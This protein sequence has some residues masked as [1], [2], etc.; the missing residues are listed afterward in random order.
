MRTRDSPGLRRHVAWSLPRELVL[1][2]RPCACAETATRLRRQRACT[3][4][5][6][7][8]FCLLALDA[9]KKA[10]R[11]PASGAAH[12]AK[13]LA[14]HF[15]PHRSPP[16]TLGGASRDVRLHM[17]HRRRRLYAALECWR[18]QGPGIKSSTQLCAL[19]H[20]LSP[21]TVGCARR[22]PLPSTC[23]LQTMLP[24]PGAQGR[25]GDG[26]DGCVPVTFRCAF[27]RSEN[28]V[29]YSTKMYQFHDSCQQ[30]VSPPGQGTNCA[31]VLKVSSTN[32]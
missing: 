11:G 8:R 29:Q 19:A 25:G 5:A 17:H 32:F 7:R 15:I 24:L 27:F 2:L 4:L 20:P 22:W 26:G 31:D 13:L 12:T 28:V 10:E 16:C 6:D 30:R 3:G 9:R 21:H 14:T 1:L 23:S 18:F